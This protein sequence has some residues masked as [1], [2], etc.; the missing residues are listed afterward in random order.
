M[1]RYALTFAT[2]AMFGLAGLAQSPRPDPLEAAKASQRIADQKAEIDVRK[3]LDDADR[4]SKSFPDKAAQYLRAAQLNLDTSAGLSNETRK[5][6]TASLQ[7]KIGAVTGKPAANPGVKLDPAGPA[8]KANKQAVWENYLAE[9][10][11]VREG[12]DLIKRHQE[13]NQTAAASKVVAELAAKYPD[14]PAVITLT[15]KDSMGNN[16]A[17]AQSFVKM[18]NERVL[19]AQNAPLYAS[20][21]PK[22]DIE[23]PANWKDRTKN[24]KNELKFSDKEKKIIEALDK[25]VTIFGKDKPLD[26]L[27]QEISTAMDQPLLIDERSLKD[28]DIDLKKIGNLDARGISARTALRQVLA[29]QGLTYVIKSETIQVMTVEK[30]RETL[31]TQ[32]YY[33]GDVVQGV[34]PFGG[35]ATWGPFLD[36]QQTMQNVAL[37]TDAIQ[38]SI[39][40][41]SWKKRGG[42]GSVTFH[43]PSM[44]I[45]VRASTEV[46]ASLGS[47][48]GSGK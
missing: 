15:R 13:A 17:D 31:T 6:L 32:V 7:A 18:Q 14:N 24:R 35:G 9:S 10:K 39:E 37:I 46:H 40:P 44:S 27:L 5:T 38:D 34:G 20:L 25:P 23:F 19:L 41:L 2:I 43:F 26:Y 11:A 1:N 42:P 28:L 36:Y 30:A 33:L 47:K 12:L 8:V 22:G 16:V 29:A 4:L 48:L 3:A 21:P 45:V